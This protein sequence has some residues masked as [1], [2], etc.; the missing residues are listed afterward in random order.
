MPIVKGVNYEVTCIFNDDKNHQ[1]TSGLKSNNQ[2]CEKELGSGNFTGVLF[3]QWTRGDYEG[4]WTHTL[5]SYWIDHILS[6]QFHI[7]KIKKKKY[8]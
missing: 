1:T 3:P 8:L 2:I 6:Y 4:H 7:S 5:L